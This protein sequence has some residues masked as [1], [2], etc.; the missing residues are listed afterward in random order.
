MQN[1]AFPMQS[2]HED[3]LKETFCLKES[4]FM[5][6]SHIKR[7]KSHLQFFSLGSITALKS[8]I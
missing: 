7:P 8:W 5:Q 2:L 6:G 4:L 1:F 3:K